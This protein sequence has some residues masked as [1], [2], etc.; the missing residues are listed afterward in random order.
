MTWAEAEYL[1]GVSV[2]NV[3]SLCDIRQLEPAKRDDGGFG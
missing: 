3:F 1:W 2:W